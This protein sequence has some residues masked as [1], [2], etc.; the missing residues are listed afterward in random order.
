MAVFSFCSDQH[1]EPPAFCGLQG[2]DEQC[3]T[4]VDLQN[5]HQTSTVPLDMMF[6]IAVGIFDL[7]YGGWFAASQS[8]KGE[9]TQPGFKPRMS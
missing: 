8:P 5:P 6:R 4:D 3:D 9:I 2:P 1:A 7:Q